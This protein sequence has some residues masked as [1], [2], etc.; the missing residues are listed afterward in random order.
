MADG[1]SLGPDV[2]P[3]NGLSNGSSDGTPLGTTN[4]PPLGL[5]NGL[6]DGYNDGNPDGV[7]DGTPDGMPDA[8]SLGLLDGSGGGWRGVKWDR[9][10]EL[11]FLGC[12]DTVSSLE[13]SKLNGKAGCCEHSTSHHQQ[14]LIL[15]FIPC[16][17]RP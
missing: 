2:G 1:T 16:A 17:S 9:Y 12:V 8:V 5:P 10:V 7:P 15:T 14:K 6:S 11:E 4:G 3:S 13:K